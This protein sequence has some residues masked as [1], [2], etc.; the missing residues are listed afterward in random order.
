MKSLLYFCIS[1]LL[2]NQLV[3][4]GTPQNSEQLSHAEKPHIKSSGGA[5]SSRRYTWV[6][7]TSGPGCMPQPDF[8]LV[9]LVQRDVSVP[10]PA[11][12]PAPEALAHPPA[13]PVVR[14]GVAV[15]PGDAH[16]LAVPVSGVTPLLP[17]RQRF[18]S[19]AADVWKRPPAQ[20][21]AA[22]SYTSS[23]AESSSAPPFGSTRT[24]G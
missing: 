14:D 10:D 9:P 2:A 18:A 21:A 1:A 22:A 4:C 15:G 23:R 12:N 24:G 11:R 16:G 8:Q 20:A 6:T 13:Q 7:A 5:L 17:A 3:G 19:T